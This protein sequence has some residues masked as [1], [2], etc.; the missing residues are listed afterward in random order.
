[1]ISLATRGAF[2]FR[3]C[4]GDNL[5]DALPREVRGSRDVLELHV[6]RARAARDIQR[7]RFLE[8]RWL[9]LGKRQNDPIV[10]SAAP[11]DSI[12]IEVIAA[13]DE[14]ARART[15]DAICTRS[16]TPHRFGLLVVVEDVSSYESRHDA[17]VFSGAL[18]GR[19]RC[20]TGR[21]GSSPCHA[22]ARAGS[23]PAA[24][25]TDEAIRWQ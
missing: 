10:A 25:T 5:A 7:A 19:V 24:S 11:H 9:P 4:A 16:R 22:Y 20:P 17:I 23:I 6:A 12:D 8:L 2:E 1:M 18:G 3:E 14:R 15:I 21:R 13:A